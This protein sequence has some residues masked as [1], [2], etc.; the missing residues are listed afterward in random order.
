MGTLYRQREHLGLQLTRISLHYQHMQLV[1][2]CLL[3][4]SQDP[5]V[6]EIF[7]RKQLRTSDFAHRWSGPKALS[8]IAP[9]VEHNLRYAGQTNHAG[10]GS[11]RETYFAKPTLSEIRAKTTETLGH[12]EEEKLMNHAACLTRQGVWTHWTIYGLSTFPGT[13]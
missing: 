11:Q 10:L 1:K 7:K 5:R 3:S 13:L 8:Q 2:A 9:I 12:L 6:Q 4:T